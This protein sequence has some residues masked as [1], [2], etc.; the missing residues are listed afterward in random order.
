M[1]CSL[2]GQ[3]KEREE[4]QYPCIAKALGKIQEAKREVELSDLEEESVVVDGGQT[5]EMT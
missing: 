5:V 3:V 2:Q 4:E 1:S